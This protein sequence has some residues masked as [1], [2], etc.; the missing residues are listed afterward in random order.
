MLLTI[1][2]KNSTVKRV[3]EDVQ[4][5]EVRYAVINNGD[6][7]ISRLNLYACTSYPIEKEVHIF[8]IGKSIFHVDENHL[9]QFD[10]TQHIPNLKVHAGSIVNI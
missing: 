5:S 8:S 2:E 1:R 7:D 9:K 4:R 3:I 10:S 6:A